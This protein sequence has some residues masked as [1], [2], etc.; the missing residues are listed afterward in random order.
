MSKNPKTSSD[1][2]KATFDSSKDREKIKILLK[3]EMILPRMVE[4]SLWD[5]D[6]EIGMIICPVEEY[7]IN[8]IFYSILDK[9]LMAYYPSP[10]FQKVQKRKEAKK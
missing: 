4:I 2:L 5:S 7:G 3:A 8:D 10:E 6:F 9:M 1:C